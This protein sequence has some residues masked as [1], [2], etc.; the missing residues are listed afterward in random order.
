MNPLFAAALA[1]DDAGLS[2]LVALHEQP[3]RE[4]LDTAIALLGDADPA[5]RRL[6]ARVLRELGPPAPGTGLRP[7]RDEVIPA[8]RARLAVE[9]DAAVLRWIISA[10]GY[11]CAGAALDE[12]LA[13]AAHPDDGVRFG[14]AAAV[15]GLVDDD[16][17]TDDALDTLERLCAD[18]DADTRW[19]A[20]H[21]LAA[22]G[23]A[24]VPAARVRAVAGRL[25]DDPDEGVR[26]LAAR[27]H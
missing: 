9:S 7:F 5:H 15:P 19:Y 6:G 21:A 27:H 14:V 1:D 4:V 20:F 10:L 23:I 25:L 11:Q 16:G 12:V 8:L 17:I 13:F 3:T 18:S 24:G 22:D 26:E 2:A